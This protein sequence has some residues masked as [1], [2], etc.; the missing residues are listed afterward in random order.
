MEQIAKELS[1]GAWFCPHKNMFRMGNYDVNVIMSALTRREK[2][3]R[4]W[5]RR[6]DLE[7]LPFNA[8]FGF[9]VNQ[10]TSSLAGLWKSKHWYA[11][12]IVNDEFYDCNSH[13]SKPKKLTK[14]ELLAL[15]KHEIDHGGEIIRVLNEEV[16]DG[17]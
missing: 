16:E 9:I 6:K 15:L 7:H 8:T 1:P 12:A 11:I 17:D 10:N 2:V 4:W 14:E 5:D 13:L 3:C